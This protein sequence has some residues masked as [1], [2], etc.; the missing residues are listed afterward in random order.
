MDMDFYKYML[1]YLKNLSS[2]LRFEFS[3]TQPIKQNTLVIGFRLFSKF[4]GRTAFVF[5][6]FM[7]CIGKFVFHFDQ[8]LYSKNAH[9]GITLEIYLKYFPTLF[10]TNDYRSTPLLN[11][12]FFWLWSFFM[13]GGEIVFVLSSDRSHAFIY[14]R[15]A[16]CPCGYQCTVVQNRFL[17]A[18]VH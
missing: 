11:D 18:K 9:L 7:I 16:F 12:Y 5:N 10:I 3:L 2:K 4:V 14:K 17:S 15:R 1:R 8:N 6:T 13:R